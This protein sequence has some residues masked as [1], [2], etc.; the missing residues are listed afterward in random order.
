MN[1]R[2]VPDEL[3][4]PDAGD[5]GPAPR[6]M[7]RRLPRGVI[8]SAYRDERDRVMGFGLSVDVRPSSLLAAVAAALERAADELDSDPPRPPSLAA[9]HDARADT[10]REAALHLAELARKR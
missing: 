10:L 5:A 1:T 3:P 8:V 2:K 6:K 4:R 9:A 7:S